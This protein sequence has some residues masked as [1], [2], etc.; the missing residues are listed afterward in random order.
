MRR[1]FELAFYVFYNTPLGEFIMAWQLRLGYVVLITLVWLS[2]AMAVTF[3]FENVDSNDPPADPLD[4]E[5]GDLPITASDA[6]RHARLVSDSIDLTDELMQ[7]IGRIES[8]SDVDMYRVH[9]SLPDEFSA[10]TINVPGVTIEDS[11]LFLFDQDGRGICANEDNPSL[12][13]S[14]PLVFFA[15]L[16]KGFCDIPAPGFYY[17]AISTSVRDPINADGDEIFPDPPL[18]ERQTL[19]L[20][21][22]LAPVVDWVDPSGIGNYVFQL[23]GVNFPLPECSQQ[24]IAEG[25]DGERILSLQ[26]QDVKL[27]LQSITV[28]S[29]SNVDELIIPNFTTGTTAPVTVEAINLN[30]N[31]APTVEVVVTNTR[32]LSTTCTLSALQEPEEPKKAPSCVDVFSLEGLPAVETTVQ[33]TESGLHRVELLF[34]KN[35]SVTVDGAPLPTAEGND[36]IEFNPPTTEPVVIRAEKINLDK[37]ATVLVE[38]FDNDIPEPNSAICDPILFTLFAATQKTYR[39]IPE[40]DRFITV[41]NGNGTP[42]SSLTEVS[43][44]VNGAPKHKIKLGNGEVV[45]LDVTAEMHQVLNTMTF[46]G[47]GLP[48]TQASIAISNQQPQIAP[49]A[50][51]GF[52]LRGSGAQH[53]SGPKPNF[54]WGQ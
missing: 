10:T 24:T 21:E 41:Q 50:F 4:T 11:Q 36:F 17:L 3:V 23:T 33:D 19:L 8:D 14:D 5:A 12:L 38:V 28:K 18:N 2:T 39:D 54:E 15:S 20:P 37:R 52:I 44:Q 16:P 7:I 42:G 13:A 1:R 40:F 6:S 26:A 49:P 29:S 45:Q 34:V 35:A 47:R 9:I 30:R 48:G 51:S 53:F 31:T 43:I 27:G 32:G 46:K 22:S 25:L